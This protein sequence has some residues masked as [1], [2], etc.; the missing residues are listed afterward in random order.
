MNCYLVRHGKDDDSV[1]GGWSDA[2]LTEHGIAQ[3]NALA[4]NLAS[5]SQKNIARIFSSDLRRAKQTAEIISTKINVPVEYLPQFRETNN[6]ALA[7]MN[8]TEALNKYPGLFWNTLNWD[9]CYPGGES[10]HTFYDRVRNAWYAFVNRIHDLDGDVILVT[11]GG[12]I[13]VIL[14]IVNGLEYSNKTKS[15]P[16]KHAELIP[17]RL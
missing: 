5:G 15:F 12:V 11:H 16:I 14:H 1:R 3:V 13:N 6:G 7:G 8:N 9:E 10:P 2:P 4:N 17:I